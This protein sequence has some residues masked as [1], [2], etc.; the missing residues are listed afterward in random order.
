MLFSAEF[1]NNPTEC[2][3]YRSGE[4]RGGDQDEHSLDYVWPKRHRIEVGKNASNITGAFNC[5]N[6]SGLNMNG[7]LEISHNKPTMNGMKK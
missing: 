4:Q 1:D 7:K 3:V 5:S 6:V 2:H